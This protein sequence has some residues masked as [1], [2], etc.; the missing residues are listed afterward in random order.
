[1][2]EERPVLRDE[3]PTGDHALQRKLANLATVLTVLK[4]LE[5]KSREAGPKLEAKGMN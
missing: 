3:I 5:I 4:R 2:G 1:M